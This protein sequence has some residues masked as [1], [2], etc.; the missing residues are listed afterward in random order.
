MKMNKTIVAT[1]IY[2]SAWKYFQETAD[3]IKNQTCKNFDVLIINDSLSQ[4]KILEK[5]SNLNVLLFDYKN[6][7]TKNRIQLINKCLEMEYENIIFIDSDDVMSTNRVESAI[8]ELD[9]CDLVVNDLDLS[10]DGKII[11]KNIFSFNNNPVDLLDL[12]TGNVMGMT[13]TSIKSSLLKKINYGKIHNKIFDWTLFFGAFLFSDKKKF[14]TDSNSIYRI[15]SK[16]TAGYFI[17]RDFKL[18]KENVLEISKCLKNIK[19]MYSCFL[20][21]EINS[22][23]VLQIKMLDELYFESE[24]YDFEKYLKYNDQLV[25]N[26]TFYWWK[27]YVKMEVNNNIKI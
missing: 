12:I 1:C 16:N 5:F 14:I 20:S 10:I 24:E 22:K 19:L 8:N 18:F 2:P 25:L 7:P 13:N 26:S 11:K 6:S 4:D 27:S 17:P 23:I 21:P 15:H 3:S 9:R